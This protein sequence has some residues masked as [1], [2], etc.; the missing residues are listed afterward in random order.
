METISKIQTD[1]LTLQRVVPAHAEAITEAI[2]DPRIYRMVARIAAG[3]TLSQTQDWI[4]T[5]RKGGQADTDH[6]FALT[7]DDSVIGCVGAHRG[8]T[9]SPFELGYWVI[10]DAWNQGYATEAGA[11]VLYWLESRGQFAAVSG[12]FA[13]NPGSGRVLSKLGFMKAGRDFQFCLGRGE[14]VEHLHMA[15]IG[16][17]A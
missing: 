8:N 13:D 5:N 15:R 11:A 12:H 10:P 1:R 7:K 17:T 9:H 6:V 16:E 3:Q 2:A 4:E 14:H